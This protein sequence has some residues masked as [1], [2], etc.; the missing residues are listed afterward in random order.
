MRANPRATREQQ[1]AERK[2]RL[3]NAGTK[4]KGDKLSEKA[5]SAKADALAEAAMSKFG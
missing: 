1:R 4:G 2:S 3:S 5:A